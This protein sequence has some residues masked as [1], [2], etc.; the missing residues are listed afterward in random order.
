M[1]IGVI[2]AG[3]LASALARRLVAGGHDV[4]ISNS[5][6]IE[7][8]RDIAAQIGCQPGSAADA[9]RFG[10]I[11]VVSIPLKDFG[12]LPIEAIGDKIVIDTGNYY[13]NRE[14]VRPEFENGLE[15]TSGYLQK[16]LPQA[17]VVKAYNSILASHL[18]AG[19]AA[20]AG[21][22]HALPIA[23]DDAAAAELVE[24][25]VRDTGLDPVNAGTLADSWKFER[26]R[27]VYCRPLNA[28]ELR[29][30]LDRTQRSDF[31]AEGS[32]SVKPAA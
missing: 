20:I 16:L 4:M 13:P 22:R 21:A 15:T 23:S 11:V 32:W 10:E 19:G 12:S 27:P 29:T 2:G 28:A 9:A 1:K 8:V 24:D 30:G 17:R 26:A 5:R 6:G 14:G 25:I 7:G 31:V 18:A 3:K